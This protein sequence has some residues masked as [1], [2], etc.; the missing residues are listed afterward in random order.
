MSEKR[1]VNIRVKFLVW[2]PGK[3]EGSKSKI[4]S[5]LIG[6]RLK[7]NLKK[8]WKL[9]FK[10]LDA[11]MNAFVNDLFTCYHFSH[12]FLLRIFFYFY[13]FII[14]WKFMTVA[15]EHVV[16]GQLHCHGV[17]ADTYQGDTFPVGNK[18]TCYN[19]I[20]L[21]TESPPPPP[22][23]LALK[24]VSRFGPNEWHFWQMTNVV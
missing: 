24:K 12:S 5:T 21:R 8:C 3:H 1:T 7:H 15:Q 14:T 6:C 23:S 19:P 20:I 18:N 10:F 22:P 9:I 11:P 17:S 2:K 13:L 4:C 16:F